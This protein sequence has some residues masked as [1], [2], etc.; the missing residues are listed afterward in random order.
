MKRPRLLLDV[1]GVLADFLAPSL[2]ILARLSGRTYVY[3]D[4]KTWDIFD[5]VPREFEKPFFDAVNQPGWC[6][7]LPVYEG[8]VA[9]VR[10]L[11][12]VT[13][14]YVVTSPMNHVPTWMFEREGWLQEHFGVHH[15]RVVHTSAKFLCLGDVLVDDRPANIEAWEAEHPGG[16]GL[17]WDQPYNR[18]SK[19][20]LRVFD[21]SHVRFVVD[22]LN[23]LAGLRSGQLTW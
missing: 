22:N 7:S 2:S 23:D 17:L 4:F 9:G 18:G 10:P 13:D 5:T 20:G 14:L 19:A 15:K 1:D 8:A 12:E 3:D 6:R 11:I 16:L 21:W